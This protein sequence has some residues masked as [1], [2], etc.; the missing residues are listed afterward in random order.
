M[1]YEKLAIDI[2]GEHI[3]ADSVR[4]NSNVLIVTGRTLRVARIKDEIYEDINDPESIIKTL[5]DIKPRADIFTFWQR[6]PETT[7]KYDYFMEWESIAVLPIKSY[8]NWLQGQIGQD[9]RKLVRRAERKGCTVR[10]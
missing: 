6:L 4:V 10:S 1:Q 3:T 8:D 5:R 9:T 7:P 2:D